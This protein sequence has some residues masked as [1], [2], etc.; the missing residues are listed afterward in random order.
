MS[1]HPLQNSVMAGSCFTAFHR[2]FFVIFNGNVYVGHA[3]MPCVCLEVGRRFT[4]YNNW[5]HKKVAP[6][7][8]PLPCRIIFF[9]NG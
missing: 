4:M 5:T 8:S 2:V 7:C 6:C 1:L 9:I 3:T